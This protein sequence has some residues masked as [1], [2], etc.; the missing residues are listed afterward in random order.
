MH[1]QS[2]NRRTSAPR[3]KPSHAAP[4]V[5]GPQSGGWPILRPF[6]TPQAR[7]A[8]DPLVRSAQYVG[9]APSGC[10]GGPEVPLRSAVASRASSRTVPAVLFQDPPPQTTLS[11][12]KVN[13]T[14]ARLAPATGTTPL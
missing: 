4:E 3:D 10:P 8:A 14:N 12:K 1:D 13:T 6:R 2:P 11:V 7:V 5:Q 9:T